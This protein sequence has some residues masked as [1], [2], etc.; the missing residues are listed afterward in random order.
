MALLQ[1]ALDMVNAHRALQI[2]REAIEGG[3]NL[4]EAGTPLIKA[5]GMNI[6]R[7]LC[8]LGIPVVADMKTMDVGLVEA[9]MAAKAGARTICVLGVASDET[10]RE[11]V[12]ASRRYGVKVMADLIGVAHVE[13][14]AT[15]VERLGVDCL[16]VHTSVDEQMTG[17]EPFATLKQ[18]VSTTRLPVA[19]AGGINAALAG[20]AVRE[21]AHTV[22]V[23][24]A[25]TK[26]AD[27]KAATQ[28]IKWALAGA[29]VPPEMARAFKKYRADELLEAF[30]QVSTCNICDAMH[31]RGAMHGIFPVKKGYHLVG[32]ALTVKTLDGDWA[33]VVEAV[34]RAAE[35]TVIVA[36]AGAGRQAVW[37]ELATHSACEKKL[38][39]VVVDGA[40]RDIESIACLDLPV[41]TRHTVPEAGEPKGHGDI[42]VEILC[43]S[44]TV[45]TGDWIVGDDNGVV[46][47]PH[48]HAQEIANR[49]LNVMERENRI[50]EEIKRGSTLSAVL[51]LERWEVQ[52]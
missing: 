4:I 13:E 42:G 19:V 11:T 43:G 12:K 5:E 17:K 26:A 48:E 16:C 39:G 45:R 14:R 7:S 8:T 10:I 37:G 27:V 25:I 50:R 20:Q 40:V 31:N 47:V 9:E 24:G 38:A 21:G 49:S 28:G 35:G 2:A 36:Q 32:Q 34:D 1:V 41:F 30:L 29:P 52:T 15:Q 44:Q 3:A 23:G 6:I 22:I 51:N 18:I 46:V 33:K